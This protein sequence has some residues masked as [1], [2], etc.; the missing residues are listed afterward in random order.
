MQNSIARERILLFETLILSCDQP[1]Y[2]ILDISM[3]CPFFLITTFLY[4][5]QRGMN[6]NDAIPLKLSHTH[7]STTGSACFC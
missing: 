7:F 3:R 5:P 1:P 2:S 4:K 6:I